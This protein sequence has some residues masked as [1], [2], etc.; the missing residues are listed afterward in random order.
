M[1]GEAI[2]LDN[3]SDMALAIPR[4]L[5]ILINMQVPVEIFNDN[6]S[7]LDIGSKGQRA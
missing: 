3:M 7:Q 6:K 4:Q 2:A 1:S 5:S